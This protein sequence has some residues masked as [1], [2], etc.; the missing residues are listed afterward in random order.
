MGPQKD[1]LIYNIIAC[2]AAV[3]VSLSNRP[4]VSACYFMKILR[5][6]LHWNSKC[7]AQRNRLRKANFPTWIFSYIFYPTFDKSDT[8]HLHVRG[9]AFNTPCVLINYMPI[10]TNFLLLWL[11][12]KFDC[13]YLACS[14]KFDFSICR[15]FVLILLFQK[16]LLFCQPLKDFQ[17]CNI[18]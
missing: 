17:S 12:R 9:E 6:E 4:I 13:M 5:P 1:L 14:Y 8:M 16:K 18:L 3:F 7:V 10:S 11:L 15:Q 2:C